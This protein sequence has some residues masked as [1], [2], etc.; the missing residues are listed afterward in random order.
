MVQ[1]IK[2]YKIF[3]S[4]AWT[5]HSEYD[6]LIGLLNQVPNFKWENCCNP[7]PDHVSVV[8]K[9]DS[10]LEL[11]LRYQMYPADVVIILLDMCKLYGKWIERETELALEMKKPIIGVLPWDGFQIPS[12]LENRIPTTVTWDVV[13]IIDAIKKYAR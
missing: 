3:V 8:N 13:S 2:T 9:T 5:D 1:E 4:H 10:E 6:Q 12:E 7:R 11:G